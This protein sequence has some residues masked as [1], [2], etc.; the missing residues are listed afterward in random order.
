M[1]KWELFSHDADMG[2]RG[3]G[4]TVE[5]AFAMAA[6]ALTAVVIEPSKVPQSKE[7]ALDLKEEGL[8]FLF[9]E[10]INHLIYEMDTQKM[11]FSHF[12][13][14]INQGKL[15]AKIKGEEIKNIHEDFGVEIK[16]ATFT[17]LKVFQQNNHWVAQCVVDI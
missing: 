8:D 16:G 9:Y 1:K 6:M 3:E 15:S 7:I 17:E 11:L 10:W 13:V 12:E 2:I 4:D 14:K 5:Q